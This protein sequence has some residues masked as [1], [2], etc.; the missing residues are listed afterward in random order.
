M[1]A[2]KVCREG[3]ITLIFNFRGTGNSGGNLD[4][5]GW[6]GDLKAAIDYLWRLEK[7]DKQRLYLVGFSGGAAVSVCVAS[8]DKRVSGVVG[9]A[10]PAEFERYLE[11]SG[12]QSI[13]EHFRDIGAIK[14]ADY[15]PSVEEWGDGF[16]RVSPIECVA[17]IAPRPLLLVH[18]D[19]DETVDISHARRLYEASGEPKQISVIEGAGHR[20]R[21]DDRAVAA[22][23]VWLKSQCGRQ[24]AS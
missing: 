14:E 1:L 6:T 17:G 16:R 21:Q 24:A 10:C 11:T 7:T 19:Q 4:L 9:C 20:L 15:P 3:F 13:I 5:A 2:E 23:L 8:Q 18:G 22:V 12:L